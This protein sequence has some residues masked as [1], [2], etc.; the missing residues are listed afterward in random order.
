MSYVG[1]KKHIIFGKLVYR[2]FS[3]DFQVDF[4]TW[5]AE[6]VV[7]LRYTLGRPQVYLR[8]TTGK[9]QVYL[10]ERVS[11]NVIVRIE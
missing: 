9:P 7:Y 3:G 1:Q 5:F 8:Y 11:G 2:R 10:E 6:L 4:T